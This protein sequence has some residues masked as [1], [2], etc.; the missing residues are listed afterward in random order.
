MEPLIVFIHGFL[1]QP[2]DWNHVVEKVSEKKILTVDLNKEFEVADLNFQ[3]WPNAFKNWLKRKK[4]SSPVKTVGY[5]MG[6]RLSLPLLDQ[7][8]VHSALVV[9]SHMGYPELAL[10]ERSQRRL[11][12]QMWAQRFLHDDWQV[13]MSDWNAQDVFKNSRSEPERSQI[14]YDRQKLSAM[15]TGFSVSDQKDYSYLFKKSKVHY[16]VGNQDQKYG[17]MALG[18]MRDFPEA[19]IE[20]I[21]NS[22]HRIIFDQPQAVAER[23][24]EL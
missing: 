8:I 20:V 7:G 9:S 15:L 10:K 21:Q 24:S 13:L 14:E 16:L 6:G 1:G 12:N 23:V 18:L 17:K 5:S 4:V 3:A 11:E 19:R 22:G 2:T